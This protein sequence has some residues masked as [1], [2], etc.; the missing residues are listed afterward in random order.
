LRTPFLLI[1]LLLAPSAVAQAYDPPRTRDGHPDFGGIWGTTFLTPLERPPGVKDLVVHPDGAKKFSDE[2]RSHV[3]PVID[4][5]FQVSD[6]RALASV[7]GELRS[8]MIVTPA[9][10]Q[11]PFSP[12][13]AKL[14]AQYSELEETTFDGPEQRPTSERCLAGMGQAP[15]RQLPAFVPSLI[16]QTPADLMIATEDV[17]AL[18]IVHI[19]GQSPPAN[20]QPTFEGW[21][22]GRW[23]GDTLVIETTHTRADDPFRAHLGRAVIVEPDSKVIERLT[24]ISA[25]ELLYQF[26]VEYADLYTAPWLAEY[27]FTLSNKP[28]YEYACHEANYSMTNML[29]AGRMGKQPKP[30]PAK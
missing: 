27:V 5:D 11:I 7:R 26:K 13:G 28:F 21:S 4:P 1:A 24:R 23:D 3:P 17:A 16:V 12:K 9:D 18:R 8:S 19:D 25:T 22:A 14:S 6:V 29:V 30:K 2:F 15:I 10:G 20:L